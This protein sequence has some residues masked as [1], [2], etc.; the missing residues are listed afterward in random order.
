M[1]IDARCLVTPIILQ[2][3]R[4]SP[5]PMY[6]NCFRYP[7]WVRSTQ[8]STYTP[9]IYFLTLSVLLEPPSPMCT[10]P[11]CVWCSGVADPGSSPGGHPLPG[12]QRGWGKGLPDLHTKKYNHIDLH[13]WL[14][15]RHNFVRALLCLR[16]MFPSLYPA[17]FYIL[18]QWSCSA[19]G[20]LRE[21]PD[22]NPG[23]LAQKSGG[24]PISHLISMN[25]HI[26]I[27]NNSLYCRWPKAR[28]AIVI[29]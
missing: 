8:Y 2:L 17:I 5:R 13:A 28:A 19:A 26:S 9:G 10:C 20:L 29:S 23:P 6:I 24:L 12:C 11:A 4:C 16:G 18:T 1:T 27:D 14:T 25:H 15:L 22:S 21:M 3:M 7:T